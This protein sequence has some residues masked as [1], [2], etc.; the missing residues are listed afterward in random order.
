VL[1][2]IAGIRKGTAKAIDNICHH[3]KKDAI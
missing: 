1:K 2:P 3:D